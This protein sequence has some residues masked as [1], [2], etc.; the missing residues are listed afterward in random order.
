[1]NGLDDETKFK[2]LMLD[3]CDLKGKKLNENALDLYYQLLSDYDYDVVFKAIKNVILTNTF[4]PQPDQIIEQIEGNEKVLV[5]SAY[6]A[7]RAYAEKHGFYKSA[8]FSD[9]LISETIKSMGG[10]QTFCEGVYEDRI[11]HESKTY[12]DFQRNYSRFLKLKKAGHHVPTVGRLAGYSDSLY[13]T[14]Q[15][16]VLPLLLKPET[17]KLE[18]VK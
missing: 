8:T 13:N 14:Y 16:D 4:F 1:M 15:D 10:L 11:Q 6:E 3:I 12:F 7:A 5:D 2:K 18:G 17:K 9:Q